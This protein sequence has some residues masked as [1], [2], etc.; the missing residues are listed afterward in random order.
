MPLRRLTCKTLVL[1]WCVMT[2][3]VSAAQQPRAA[4]LL[5]QYVRLNTSNP[6]G[7]EIQAARFFAK[8]FEQAGIPYQVFEA[9]PGRGNIVARL[10]GSSA[11]PGVL[12]LHHMDVVAAEQSRWDY[13][14]FEARMVDGYMH[15]RGTLDN[16]A[17]GIFQLLAFLAL[18]E[19]GQALTRDVI[20]MA[21]AD[22]EAGGNLGVKWLLEKHPE[23][24]DGVGA[25]LN[26]GG[27]GARRDG[28]LSFGIEVTQKVPLW[29]RIT[30]AGTPGHAAAPLPD[31]APQRL[32]RAL[33]TFDNIKFKAR[34]LPVVGQYLARLAETS[35][36]PWD[37]YLSTPEE[38][39]GSPALLAE[40]RNYNRRL[41]VLLVNT[42]AVTRLSGSAKINVVPAEAS[43]EVDCRLLPDEN[44]EQV[45]AEIRQKLSAEGVSVEPI[46]SFGPGSSS[47]DNF[48]YEAIEQV[49]AVHYPDA[50]VLAKMNAGFTDSHYFREKGI[51]AFGFSPLILGASDFGGAHGDNEKISLENVDLG[52]KLTLEIL[53]KL[54]YE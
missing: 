5:A 48:L 38:L 27:S 2:V 42:C 44:P 53:Q 31:S 19:Q 9:E 24:I 32:I 36:A 1:L 25:V 52:A 26:E 51:P 4:E 18:H 46:L 34:V 41:Y 37:K 15:G 13:A 10:K 45:L 49:L 17:S 30:A 23:L 20:F 8:I 43:A 47:K 21:T 7:Q 28:K 6:P 22:E 35:P 40:L 16:K 3:N 29:L 11:K 54:S 14:P 50:P 12:L 39:V 33:N